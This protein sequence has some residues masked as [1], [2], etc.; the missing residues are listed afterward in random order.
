MAS[1]QVLWWVV[2]K[3]C[4]QKLKIRKIYLYEWCTG[5]NKLS[6]TSLLSRYQTVI[7][8]YF[9]C[10]WYLQSEKGHLLTPSFFLPSV[11][12]IAYEIPQ[13]SYIIQVSGIIQTQTPIAHAQVTNVTILDTTL[14]HSRFLRWLKFRLL[15]R[16]TYKINE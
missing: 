13:S 1:K 8:L 15:H 14:P 10:Q 5:L 6:Q 9:S 12:V 2:R 11:S 7:A 4:N 16:H 3:N